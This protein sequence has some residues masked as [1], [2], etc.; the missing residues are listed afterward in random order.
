M[1]AT[2]MQGQVGPASGF[3]EELVVTADDADVVFR[4]RATVAQIEALLGLAGIP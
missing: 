4:V 2:T 1:M 3:F